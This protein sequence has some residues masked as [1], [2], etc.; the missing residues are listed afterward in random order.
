MSKWLIPKQMAL[1]LPKT[2]SIAV[3]PFANLSDDPKQELLADGITDNI[4]NALSK[5]P[6]CLSSHGIRLPVQGKA[7]KIKQVSEE[8]VYGMCWKAAFR[9]QPTVSGSQRN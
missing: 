4:V 3:L 6:S 2:P 1:P 7:V 5:V 8:L 9:T